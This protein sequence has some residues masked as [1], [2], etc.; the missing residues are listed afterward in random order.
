M[1]VSNKIGKRDVPEL[2]KKLHKLEFTCP[3]NKYTE[4]LMNPSKCTYTAM[5]P[6]RPTVTLSVLNLMMKE[7]PVSNTVEFPKL[8]EK[9]TE[10]VFTETEPSETLIK[11]ADWLLDWLDYVEDIL[12]KERYSEMGYLDEGLCN[13]ITY[14]ELFYRHYVE[15]ISENIAFK[16]IRVAK[17]IKRL[18]NQLIELEKYQKELDTQR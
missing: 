4:W 2:V 6:C 8:L 18:K 13:N 1:S 14:F 11:S 7:I 3:R 5:D 17:E 12:A 10:F 9:V 16:K 15:F